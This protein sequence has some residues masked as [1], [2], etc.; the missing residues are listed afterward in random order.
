[1]AERGRVDIL[2]GL[3]Y[4]NSRVQRTARALDAAGWNVRVLA[5]DREAQRP[6]HARDGRIRVDHSLV[7]SHSGRGATQLAYLLRALHSHTRAI[8]ADPPD[9]LHVV[10]L[11][12]LAGALAM[13]PLGGGRRLVY[14]AF[15][16]YALM[17]A[18]RYPR[19]LLRGVDIAERL[20]PRRADLVITPGAGRAAWFAER[21]IDSVVVGNWIDAPERPQSRAAAR[22]ALGI[23]AERFMILYAGDLETSRD[24]QALLRH[25]E[26][27]PG[28]LIVI[29]GRGAQA[30]AVER[31]ANRLP[32]VRWDGWLESTDAHHAAADVLYYALHRDHPYAAHPAPNNLYAAIAH[33]VPLIHRGQG[34]I[35]VL[36]REAEIGVAF[37]DDPS[38]DA[39]V[40]RLRDA[41]LRRRIRA[42][43]RGLQSRYN[44][45]ATAATLVEA[46]AALIPTP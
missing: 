24:I 9:V 26:R 15:E 17:Q 42:S 31:F 28:D 27:S 25:A 29:A 41:T 21:G 16:L 18:E 38:L 12:V 6:R 19:W 4:P 2:F 40:D 1:M 10:D 33:G 5:W 14:D 20:L 35:G 46:Y 43:L 3:S 32:N 23:P 45:R 34:E 39:A 30:T 44:E 36:A 37:D 11:P 22:R 7:R 13:W 8:R